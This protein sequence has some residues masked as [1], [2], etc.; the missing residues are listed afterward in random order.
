MALEGRTKIRM[1]GIDISETAVETAK[2]ISSWIG[3]APAEFYAEN[4]A[5]PAE[6]PIDCEG[7]DVVFFSI[8]VLNKIKILDS[9]VFQILVSRVK[10]YGRIRFVLIESFGWQIYRDKALN[11][12]FWKWIIR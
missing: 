10:N 5:F 6:I 7:R 8:S 9:N 3:D 4:L 2:A 12:F 11:R 1:V